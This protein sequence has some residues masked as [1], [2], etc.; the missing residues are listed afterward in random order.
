MHVHRNWFWSGV[1]SKRFAGEVTRKH[2]FGP[3][4]SGWQGVWEDLGRGLGWLSPPMVWNLIPLKVS[5]QIG[6][7]V[8]LVRYLAEGTLAYGENQQL[9]GLSCAS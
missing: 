8:K 6:Q 5:N 7:T 3:S 4:I 9:L 2:A 1:K